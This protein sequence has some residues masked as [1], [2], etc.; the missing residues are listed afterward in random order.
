[1]AW[2]HV[3]LPCI[4]YLHL[5]FFNNNPKS[6]ALGLLAPD[7]RSESTGCEDAQ[8]GQF[9]FPLWPHSQAEGP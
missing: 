7:S 4:P 2:V 9:P 1:M 3:L 5:Q 6:K 8:Q